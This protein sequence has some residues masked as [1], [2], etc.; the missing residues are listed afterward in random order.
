MQTS[1]ETNLEEQFQLLVADLEPLYSNTN[2]YR[3]TS[4][5]QVVGLISFQKPNNHFSKT[6]IKQTIETIISFIKAGVN[7]NASMQ[8]N[9]FVFEKYRNPND[10]IWESEPA[11]PQ[12]NL[13]CITNH[14]STLFRALIKQLILS[15]HVRYL[16]KIIKAVRKTHDDNYV[17]TLVNYEGGGG[18]YKST[19]LME[20]LCWK[21]VKQIEYPD[22]L[23]IQGDLSKVNLNNIENINGTFNKTPNDEMVELLLQYGADPNKQTQPANTTFSVKFKTTPLYC[24]IEILSITSINNLLQHG[25]NV[26][27]FQNSNICD[28]LLKRPTLSSCINAGNDIIKDRIF[29]PYDTRERSYTKRPILLLGNNLDNINSVLELLLQNGFNFSMDVLNYNRDDYTQLHG[30]FDMLF[31][32]KN[33]VESL[34]GLSYND[35]TL[36]LKNILKNLFRHALNGNIDDLIL[37][38]KRLRGK[39]PQ[40]SI[41]KKHL[42]KVTAL[43]SFYKRYFQTSAWLS[44]S[45]E[46]QTL[47][48]DIIDEITAVH[49]DISKINVKV[50]KGEDGDKGSLYDVINS[51]YVSAQSV[52]QN[53]AMIGLY[54][55]L[56]EKCADGFINYK[57]T[58]IVEG[59][60]K[61]DVV[62]VVG[63]RINIP[64]I[65]LS[66]LK[67]KHS[68]GTFLAKQNESGSYELHPV[69]VAEM[70]DDDDDDIQTN[71]RK[72]DTPAPTIN[73][74]ANWRSIVDKNGVV[75][76]FFNLTFPAMKQSKQ[77]FV[78]IKKNGNIDETLVN[79]F[80]PVTEEEYENILKASSNKRF[81]TAGKKRLTHRFTQK[82]WR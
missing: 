3:Q 74:Y 72:L 30:Y 24:A 38:G 27:Q 61:G 81:K 21:W 79:K 44:N 42:K 52:S 29:F 69:E 2:K 32:N 51:E 25:L 16:N 73:P 48:E 70:D 11:L 5:H 62:D 78:M 41:K 39:I 8:T 55:E 1:I 26:Q 82:K 36:L 28:A 4:E 31:M 56:P 40:N 18:N 13:T 60:I 59:L 45:V 53:P 37:I 63:T 23:I 9:N 35:A 14:Y 66:K 80:I 43:H 67:R 50:Q 17:H 54:Q 19:P 64:N 33:N 49:H 46:F 22:E 34:N 75:T 65:N 71:K 76:H 58:C 57:G 12:Y 20:A 6:N 7:L 68:I 15:K 77:N 47:I 10:S